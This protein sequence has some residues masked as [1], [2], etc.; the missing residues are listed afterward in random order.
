MVNLQYRIKEKSNYP[1]WSRVKQ[2]SLLFPCT[3]MYVTQSSLSVCCHSRLLSVQWNKLKSCNRCQKIFVMD[4]KY[5]KKITAVCVPDRLSNYYIRDILELFL[6]GYP[7]LQE[8]QMK[9]NFTL[10]VAPPLVYP[11]TS[12]SATP[13]HSIWRYGF[14]R[15]PLNGDKMP[16]CANWKC[17][18][19]LSFLVT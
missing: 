10:A 14:L 13:T 5:S 3:C 11:M 15:E 1:V 18:E 12:L 6:Q 17:C 16:K 9:M 19:Y 2:S 4:N 8:S 7:A